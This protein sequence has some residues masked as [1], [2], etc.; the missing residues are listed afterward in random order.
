MKAIEDFME[1]V[2]A[3]T[4]TSIEAFEISRKFSWKQWRLAWKPFS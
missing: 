4:E 3:S 2:V 1:E